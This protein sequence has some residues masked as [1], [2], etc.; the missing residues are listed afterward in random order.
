MTLSR[1]DENGNISRELLCDEVTFEVWT[2]RLLSRSIDC[3]AMLEYYGAC[4]PG[5][6]DA[7]VTVEE[8]EALR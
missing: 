1:G 6:A 3:M 8:E 7:F 5:I 4:C 2:I